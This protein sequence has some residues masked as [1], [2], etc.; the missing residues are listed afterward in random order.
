MVFKSVDKIVYS[1]V[2]ALFVL[3]SLGYFSVAQ[4][5]GVLSINP[6]SGQAKTN[7]P[8]NGDIRLDTKG[9]KADATQ[10]YID[11]D[12]TGGQETF[13]LSGSRLFNSY[14]NIKNKNLPS[15]VEDGLIG[16]GGKVSGSN[17]KFASFK[18]KS[19][20]KGKTGQV[21]IYFKPKKNK[22][23][24]VA[25]NGTNI[26]SK[27]NNGTINVVQGYCE[28]KKPNVVNL[29]PK[30]REPNHPVDKPIKFDLTDN[31]SG[32][33]ISTLQV[34]IKHNNKTNKY[35]NQDS[36]VTTNKI[37]NT[38]Y[39]VEVDPQKDFTPQ[40][41]VDVEVQVKDK[42]GNQGKRK[43][44]FNDLTCKQLG[45]VGVQVKTQ[46]NDGK[47]NDGDGKIDLN[48]PGCS[49]KSDNNEYQV[50]LTKCN[51]GRDNDGDGLV[52]FADPGCQ[53]EKA[54]VQQQIK[55][56]T[57][58][59]TVIKT[60][61]TTVP[62]KVPDKTKTV[63]KTVQKVITSTVREVETVTT[64]EV[65]TVT[66]KIEKPDCNDGIDNDGDKLTDFPEDPGCDSKQDDSEFDKATQKVLQL[67]D[68]SFQIGGLSVEPSEGRVVDVLRG[69]KLNVSLNISKV[70]KTIESVE[71]QFQD[72]K[73]EMFYNNETGNYSGEI[74]I[75]EKRGV[76]SGFVRAN[77][78]D[79][80]FDSVPFSVLVQPSGKIVG[81]NK[82]G[83]ISGL[84]GAN[85][86]IQKLEDGEYTEFK[87]TK[88]NKNGIYSVFVPNGVYRL[89]ISKKGYES[90]VTAGFEVENNIINKKI[91]LLED[92]QLLDPNVSTGKKIQYI[93]DLSVK[94]TKEAGELA[95]DPTVEKQTQS[96]IA[97]AAAA[98]TGAA[99]APALGL[100][101]L[102]NYLRFLFFQ[103][104]LLLGR[105]KREDWGVVYNS[106]TR[107]TIDLA[108]VR[109][110]DFESDEVVQS[111]V[112]DAEGRY[113]F[114]AKPGKYR[115]KVEKEQFDFPTENLSDVDE[116]GPYTDIYHGEP[117]RVEEEDTAVAP[118]IPLDPVEAE[119]KTPSRIKWDKIKKT[120]Q[121]YL[122]R[123]GIIAG[124]I[125][126]IINPTW[127][128]GILLAAQIGIY[129]LFRRLGTTPEPENWGII[130]EEDTESPVGEAT[131][132]LFTKDRN[133]LVSTQQTD[134]NGRY[135]FLAGPKDYY[136]RVD[137]E[138]YSPESKEV[139]VEEGEEFIQ[140]DVDLK[141]TKQGPK[142]EDDGEDD[143]SFAE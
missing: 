135:A 115:I 105:R 15:G 19:P 79:G 32:V 91:Q 81:R 56:Q 41:R 67:S 136:V 77:Y 88:T 66:K 139:S 97:P 83:E 63:T 3:V 23:S 95:D 86:K 71:L 134:E 80:D 40:V 21:K 126:M 62:T 26:L 70:E 128:I 55:T 122:A 4:A 51:D 60:K 6:S 35:S 50:G 131:V 93:Q 108:V 103:P 14:S 37:N 111:R 92:I 96:S 141:K 104:L 12:F 130:K 13:S 30:H 143:L 48:D 98:A 34:I 113:I 22:T 89:S 38:D 121:K 25:K 64:T 8:F 18:L 133:K 33:D 61:T 65:A 123:L 59:N 10:V 54:Q 9:N 110:V 75:D 20:N 53:S 16:Y 24:K 52:D 85:I 42:A 129:Y 39:S 46:C 84:K 114:F 45:C 57:V 31:S 72:Q 125:S 99:V 107:S 138:G 36:E 2:L 47:D 127:L 100:V 117:I 27:V 132:R 29:D 82:E 102:L 73:K 120:A 44:Y 28:N 109:L 90:D 137:K 94:K 43:Y 142:T 58:T 76:Y 1:L 87:Q 49:S 17:L 106:L 5:K 68:V 74:T 116:D 69:S 119:E 124:V 11:H 78:S 140:E 7:C 118:N 112:T 101:N